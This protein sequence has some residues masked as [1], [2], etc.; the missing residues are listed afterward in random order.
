[1]RLLRLLLVAAYW[2]LLTVLLL[3]PNPAAILGFF[4]APKLPT[5]DVGIHFTAFFILSVLVCAARWPRRL[6]WFLVALLVGYGLL[7]E[8][9]Q[10][11]V[12]PRAV[13][14]LDYTENVLGVLAASGVYWLLQ[15]LVFGRHVEPAAAD[16]PP[17][18]Q[19]AVVH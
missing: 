14:L 19:T 18:D 3:V 17:Q 13:E 8:S 5:N 4:R 11:L 1:M 2:V 16:T 10:A 12:P 7:V 9:L 15:R 6:G